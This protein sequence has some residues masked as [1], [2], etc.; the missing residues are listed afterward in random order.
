MILIPVERFR[1]LESA[2][3]KCA[4]TTPI[5]PIK[6]QPKPDI[7]LK[8]LTQ[9]RIRNTQ[10]TSTTPSKQQPDSSATTPT[11][12]PFK[13]KKRSRAK[14]FVK[15]LGRHKDRILFNKGELQ[16]DGVK[17][18]DSDMD[19]LTSALVEDRRQE[20]TPG[21]NALMRA[22]EATGAS[23]S[24]YGR[25]NKKDKKGDWGSLVY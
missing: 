6:Q 21:W 11:I 19:D 2:A 17:I 13:G 3:T 18:G 23:P 25:W 15:H 5:T 8:L 1:A 12:E 16:F 10:R 24:L 22:L 4:L 14:A 20:N 7:D 9:K